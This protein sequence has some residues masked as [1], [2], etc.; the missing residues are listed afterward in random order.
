MRPNP[1]HVAA[2]ALFDSVAAQDCKVQWETASA[3]ADDVG[4]WLA[5]R[6]R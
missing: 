5:G 3:S 2:V 1:R 6:N 4:G